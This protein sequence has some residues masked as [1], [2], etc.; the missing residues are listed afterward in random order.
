MIVP[1]PVFGVILGFVPV[2][3]VA[4]TVALLVGDGRRTTTMSAATTHANRHVTVTSAAG[5]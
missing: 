3:A 5:L 4:M 2:L 1:S